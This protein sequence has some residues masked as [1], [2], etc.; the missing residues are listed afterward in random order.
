MAKRRATTGHNEFDPAPDLSDD[1]VWRRIAAA[2]GHE[3]ELDRI[4]KKQ[5]ERT[6]NP[7]SCCARVRANNSSVWE[8]LRGC[9]SA[10]IAKPNRKPQ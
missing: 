4:A 7:K 8:Q 6:G 2:I 10:K 9:F 3:V 1:V 5:M